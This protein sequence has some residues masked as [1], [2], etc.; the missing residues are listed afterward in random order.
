MLNTIL[1]FATY[2]AFIALVRGSRS[3]AATTIQLVR[4]GVPDEEV[5]G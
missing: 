2:L 4:E 5:R 3:T 1:A